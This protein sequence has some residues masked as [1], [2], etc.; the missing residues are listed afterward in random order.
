[1]IRSIWPYP[2][3]YGHFRKWSAMSLG[4]RSA[5]MFN[6]RDCLCDRTDELART[7]TAEHG[8]TLEDAAGEIARGIEVA[9]YACAIPHLLE[10]RYSYNAST[11]V[12]VVSLNQPLGCVA[13]VSP[14][15]FP[16][17]VPLW[18][19][20]VALACG[21]TVV[22]KPSERDPSAAT[23]LAE[24]FIDAGGPPGAFNVVH[25]NG[26]SVEA[27]L[28][29]PHIAA[30]SLG[31]QQETDGTNLVVYHASTMSNSGKDL[32]CALTTQDLI[33]ALQC[34]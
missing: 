18:F 30:I 21:N 34:H 27:M 5:V 12:D 15:N 24:A 20:P 6:F 4:R 2:L 9:E 25:G 16:A 22:L 8:K 1:M 13:I 7:I 11:N 14:F 26:T 10:G 3:G 31:F 32:E 17:M 23:I 29:H 28:H 19:A 33:S